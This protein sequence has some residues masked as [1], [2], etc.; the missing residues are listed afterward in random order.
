MGGLGPADT[1]AGQRGD[2]VAAAE[3]EGSP[4]GAPSTG[5][6]SAF[7][8]RLLLS[9]RLPDKLAPL[10]RGAVA[11]AGLSGGLPPE[12][13]GR[14]EALRFAPRGL[15]PHKPSDGAL[16][17]A[18]ARA[19]LLHDFANHELLAIELMALCLLRWPEA[20]LPFRRGLAAVIHEEQ[21]HLQGYIDRIGEL[22]ASFGEH[23]LNGFFY[24]ALS[25][26]PSPLAFIEGMSLVLEQANLD[27]CQYWAGRLR[28][29]GDEQ[30]AALLDAVRED[31]IGHLRHGLRWS[32]AWRPAGEDD[33][34][35]LVAQVEP[36]GLGRCRGP[37]FDAE[38]RARAGLSAE[39]I[40][41]LALHGRSRDRPPAVWSFDPGVEA[42]AQDRAR[43]RRPG[44]PSGPAAALKGDLAAVPLALMSDNDVIVVPHAPAEDWL[45]H[46][47]AAGLPAVE[48]ASEP[49]ALAGRALGPSRPWGWPGAPR[50]AEAPPD[51][52]PDPYLWSKAWAAERAPAVRAALGLPAE[53]W[54]LVVRSA[55]ALDLAVAELGAQ[56]EI[57]LLRAPFGA[58]GRGAQRWTG[59]PSAA[60][61]QWARR[62]LAEQG[63]LVLSPWLA[64][65]LDLSCHAD[66]S[67]EGRLV[68]R[69]QVRF[70][71][72]AQG[73]FLGA[74]TH[75]P[76][77]DLPPAL[78]RALAE[79]AGVAG[80]PAGLGAAVRSALRPALVA[81]GY[82]GPL[83][84]DQLL[85]AVDQ[86]PAV[87]RTAEPAAGPFA[88]LPLV[89]LNARFTFG[90]IALALRGRQAPSA[91]GRLRLGPAALLR[92]KLDLHGAPHPRMDG[93]GRIVEAVVPL[94]DPRRAT[95]AAAVWVVAA[96]EAGLRT[97]E[98]ALGLPPALL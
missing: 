35:R 1:G 29:L 51:P 92:E 42:A 21:R 57:V 26:A 39:A 5:A 68:M 78:A 82:H 25:G 56:H 87:D 6:L 34:A 14:P 83:G 43:G 95:Q 24:R 77:L 49:A 3:L 20:P 76:Q 47:R 94:T 84:L 27:F 65:A 50:W 31:E 69:G 97:A 2:R 73:R 98:A 10:D 16:A 91:R 88:W 74:S 38:G 41:S 7:A 40:R 48:W 17:D 90:R 37:V 19:A 80:G 32:R 22:G 4:A 72:D 18:G 60:Q 86:R 67:P 58:S 28:R 8:E 93:Q 89:E 9:D 70:H 13:P 61:R 12:A 46:L 15:R 59:P 36:L 62:A 30:S 33:W 81:A 64:R 55:E 71:N 11:G 54:P 53:G 96:D 23:P 85:Y 52:E 45:A 44:P 63:A 75:A 79:A 66:L